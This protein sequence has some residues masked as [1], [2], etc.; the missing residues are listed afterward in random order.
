LGHAVY[1][2]GDPVGNELIEMSELSIAE[3]AVDVKEEIE[4]IPAPDL[5]EIDSLSLTTIPHVSSPKNQSA[6]FPCTDSG[7]AELFAAVCGNSVRYDHKRKRWLIWKASRWIEDR[8]HKVTVAATGVARARARA[9]FNLENED[10]RKRQIAWSFTSESSARIEAALELAK[11][12]EPISDDGEGWDADPYLFGVA[13]GIVDL[14]TGAFRRATQSDKVTKFNHV[15]FAA[16]AT[17]PRFLEF[18]D[19]IFGDTDL[20]RFLQLGTGYSLTGSTC[21]QCLFAVTARAAMGNR[22]SLR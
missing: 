2:T 21:E 19:Q 22:R 15:K 5:P 18:L 16:G 7:N 4:V 11:S 13:N 17:C 10:D 12:Q 1:E 3:I 14:R 20:V 9:A 6:T 8:Q